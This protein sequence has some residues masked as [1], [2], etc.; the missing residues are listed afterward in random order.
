MYATVCNMHALTSIM[1]NVLVKG[2]LLL[3][4]GS[5]VHVP[6]GSGRTL[7]G[8]VTHPCGFC[9]LL[10]SIAEISLAC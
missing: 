4:E 2:F 9:S 6:H 8:P 3:E 7:E 10:A 1:M 5:G